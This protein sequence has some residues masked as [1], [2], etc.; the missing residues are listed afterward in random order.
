MSGIELSREEPN[1]VYVTNVGMPTTNLAHPQAQPYSVLES[2][3]RLAAK[4]QAD[5]IGVFALDTIKFNEHWQAMLGARWDRFDSEYRSTGYSPAGATIATTSVNH[6]DESPSFRAALLYKPVEAATFYLSYGDSFNP[7]AEGIE[8]LVSSGR[9]VAQANLNVDPEESRTY[10]LGAKWE[11]LSGSALLSSAI[12][13]IEKTNARVPDPLIPGFNSLGGEQ[14][15]DGFEIEL[16]GRLT[17]AWNVRAGYSYLDSEVIR[18]ERGGPLKGVPLTVAPKNSASIWSEY[19]LPFGAE[20][21]LGAVS[22][23]SRL[24]QNT[25]SA[26]LVAPGYTTFDAMAKYSVGSHLMLQ[27][28]VSNLTDKK[29]FDQ[30]HPFHVVPGP[31]RTALLSLQMRY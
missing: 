16:V 22:L 30:L 4:T 26:Y 27:L 13:R 9:A 20:V 14:R 15:V 23:S 29:Y 6:V 31:G 1:P 17:Q 10:E 28:N 19:T 21:G 12:F 2:N 11:L 3:P 25:A 24:A 5:S 8:S 7:S 18:S